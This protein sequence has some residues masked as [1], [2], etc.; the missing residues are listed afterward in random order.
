MME[1]AVQIFVL[2]PAT[3]DMLLV[4]LSEIFLAKEIILQKVKKSHFAA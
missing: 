3:M 4:R 1:K 2:L